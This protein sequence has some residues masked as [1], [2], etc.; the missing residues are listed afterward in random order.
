ML[1]IGC[2]HRILGEWVL[3]QFSVKLHIIL[4]PPNLPLARGRAVGGGV[5]SML[6]HKKL[7]LAPNIKL[8]GFQLENIFTISEKIVEKVDGQKT[9]IAEAE[10]INEIILGN[11]VFQNL[12][13]TIDYK[14]QEIILRDKD[15][16]IR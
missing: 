9:S 2:K 10:G 14:K 4:T 11:T 8:G 16:D 1:G 3:Y 5:L 6:L 13:L 12:V 7:V 15:Y